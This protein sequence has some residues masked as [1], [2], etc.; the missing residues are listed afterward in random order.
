MLTST[1]RDKVATF[2]MLFGRALKKKLD[3]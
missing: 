3:F 1:G 2:Y